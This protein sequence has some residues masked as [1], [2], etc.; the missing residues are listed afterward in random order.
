MR[1]S[2][3]GLALTLLLSGSAWAQGHFIIIANDE[4]TFFEANG[5]RNGP[6]GKD[7]VS[8]VDISQPLSPRIVANLPLM[9]S[10]LGPPTNLQITPDG[11]LGLVANPV[12]M[13]QDGAVWRA[14]PDNKLHVIDLAATPPRLVESIEVGRQPS[15]MAISRK[16]DLA[17]VA[18]RNGKS[19]SVLTIAGTTV[20]Q[21]A[22]IPMDDE[23]AA[24]AITPDGKRAFVAKNAAHKV[25]VLTIDGTK[26]SYDKAQDMVVGYGVYNID[27]T[28]DGRFA[29]AANTGIGGD[30]HSDTVSVIDARANPPRVVDN[31]NVGDGPEG[32]AIAPNGRYAV[33]ALLKGSAAVHSAWS[34]TRNGAVRL[35]R[36]GP[37]GRLTPLGELPAGGLPEGLAFSP[38]SRYVY[39]GN[40]VD[41]TLQV[42]RITGDRLSDTGVKLAL[43]GQPAAIRGRP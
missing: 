37:G 23:V 26:V 7:S 33:A 18:N 11:R 5:P 28:P 4:K 30:G 21:I 38:D 36:I 12:V 31:V 20:R 19:V 3:F 2:L 42:Y 43:P 14:A 17:L 13:N 15:G 1:K 39:V 34:Y 29:L 8:I 35:I 24:V 27:V 10:V 22:E 25:A 16:G 40:Y 6:P 9:N 41:R 32:F